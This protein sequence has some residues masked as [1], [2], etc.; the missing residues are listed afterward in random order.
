METKP[1][2]PHEAVLCSKH[3]IGT[4]P[5]ILNGA[6]LI[7]MGTDLFLFPFWHLLFLWVH[8]F[9]GPSAVVVVVYVVVVVDIVVVVVVVV[10]NKT[11]SST[12]IG[13][14]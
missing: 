9:M 6:A 11:K 1:A 4:D 7:W 12:E 13:T 14:Q 2:V 10:W 3:S 5:Y 8:P